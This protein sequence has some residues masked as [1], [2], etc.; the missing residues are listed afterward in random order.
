MFVEY[1]VDYIVELHF[2]FAFQMETAGQNIHDNLNEALDDQTYFKLHEA[3]GRAFAEDLNHHVMLWS[4]SESVI[5][6]LIGIGQVLVLRSF[7][8]EKKSS[9]I[10]YQKLMNS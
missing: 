9:G 8:T 6:L 10:G 1:I 5:V 7:F 2:V 3:Q 4:I